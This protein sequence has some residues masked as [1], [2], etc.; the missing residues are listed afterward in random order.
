MGKLL[1]GVWLCGSMRLHGSI[2][3][4]E[5]LK[6]RMKDTETALMA[7]AQNA[8]QLLEQIQLRSRE[9]FVDG[10]TKE[11]IRDALA[12]LRDAITEA[13]GR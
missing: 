1:R 11:L 9:Y 4:D 2:N 3:D 7:A 6:M 5:R 8:V 12:P 10:V 13:K